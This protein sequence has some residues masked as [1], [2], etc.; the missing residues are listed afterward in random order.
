M[1]VQLYSAAVQVGVAVSMCTVGHGA[2]MPELNLTHVGA[3][4]GAW[5][6]EPAARSMDEAWPFVCPDVFQPLP[7]R[8]LR[9]TVQVEERLRR[10]LITL[11]FLSSVGADVPHLH[12]P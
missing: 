11:L 2:A 10:L 12:C 8:C 1:V 3:T 4:L 7:P 9:H 5:A 6:P